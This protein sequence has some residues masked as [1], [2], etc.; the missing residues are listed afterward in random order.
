MHAYLT[1][2]GFDYVKYVSSGVVYVS[3]RPDTC[4]DAVDLVFIMDGSNSMSNES[5]AKDVGEGHLNV[6]LLFSCSW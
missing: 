4:N 3:V 5:W 2:T 1:Q 6:L